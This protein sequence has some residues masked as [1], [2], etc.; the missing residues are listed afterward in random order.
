MADV[1]GLCTRVHVHGLPDDGSPAPEDSELLVKWD[2]LEARRRSN[3]LRTHS[4]ANTPLLCP[5]LVSV[6][7][8]LRR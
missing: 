5:A 2:H 1:E 3:A 4:N 7:L 8:Q 6:L